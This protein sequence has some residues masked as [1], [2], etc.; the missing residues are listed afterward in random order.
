MFGSIGLYHAEG[1][2]F[3]SPL[4]KLK[5]IPAELIREKLAFFFKQPG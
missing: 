2:V 1:D 5:P 4:Q 3:H